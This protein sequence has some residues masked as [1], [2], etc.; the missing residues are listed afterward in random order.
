MVI[1]LLKKEV[2]CNTKSSVLTLGEYSPTNLS[3][4]RFHPRGNGFSVNYACDCVNLCNFLHPKIPRDSTRLSSPLNCTTNTPSEVR[5]T[6]SVSWKRH[7]GCCFSSIFKPIV[8]DDP[9]GISSVLF[10]WK[11]GFGGNHI[12]DDPDVFFLEWNNCWLY[13]YYNTE[14]CIT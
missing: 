8:L 10:V 6:D 5:I 9:D 7:L 14:Q 11:V 1:Y 3:L 13:L 2:A 12:L 4:P